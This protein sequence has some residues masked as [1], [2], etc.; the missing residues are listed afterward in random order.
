MAIIGLDMESFLDEGRP[1]FDSAALRGNPESEPER[2]SV[3]AWTSRARH[4]RGKHRAMDRIQRL[5]AFRHSPPG[6]SIAAADDQRRG[7]RGVRWATRGHLGG[8]VQQL[9]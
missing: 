3:C 9:Q 1:D 7:A 5:D 2:L 4:S 8:R 6:H